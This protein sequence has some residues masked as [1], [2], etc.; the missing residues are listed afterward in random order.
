LK[1][2]PRP[3]RADVLQAVQVAGLIRRAEILAASRRIA[4]NT[5]VAVQAARDA[6][7]QATARY[8]ARSGLRRAWWPRRSACSRKAEIDD[9][10]ARLN[11]RRAQLLLA[12]AVG[13]LGPFLERA[14]LMFLV[15]SALAGGP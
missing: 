4:E 15:L 13:D 8:R 3:A 9:S 14:S 6:E 7:R 2:R 1:A 5:P 10:V 11:V 12:R